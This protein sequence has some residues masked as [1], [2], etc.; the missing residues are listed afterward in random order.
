MPKPN[1]ANDFSKDV[2][3]QMQA[4]LDG[5]SDGSTA[6]L[7]GGFFRCDGVI[8]VKHRLRIVGGEVKSDTV[9]KI[10][11]PRFPKNRCHF[12]ITGPDVEIEGTKVNGPNTAGVFD[13]TL[14][15]QH[16]FLISG[17]RARLLSTEVREVHGDAWKIS[18]GAAA[19]HP[20]V[21]GVLVDGGVADVIGRQGVSYGDCTD[22]KVR[23]VKFSNVARSGAD[24]EPLG[25]KADGEWT[26]HEIVKN[27]TLEDCEFR[28]ITHSIIA[29]LGGGM[30]DGMN[31]LRNKAF[32]QPFTAGC[33]SPVQED[34]SCE[35]RRNYVFDG[36]SSDTKASRSP[37][38]FI[39]IDGYAVR[40]HTQP[41]AVPRTGAAPLLIHAED[42]TQIN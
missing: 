40:N 33:I 29:N 31:I 16:G 26:V 7:T 8:D 1:F 3:A 5:L 36:N 20:P 42:S 21:V 18:G 39:R 4:W 35:R 28:N 34:G 37:L 38:D 24:F 14:E 41:M 12:R 2:T 32:G 25:K 10:D 17:P 30:V 27:A 11:Q 22:A 9:G 15:F 23:R 19:H 13:T 6:D